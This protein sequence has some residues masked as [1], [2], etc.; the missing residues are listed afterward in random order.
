MKFNGTLWIDKLSAIQT[1]EM[2]YFSKN[3]I[4]L[5]AQY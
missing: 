3:N 1:I 5:N 2:G 4:A